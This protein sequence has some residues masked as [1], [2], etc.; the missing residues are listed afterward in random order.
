M[1]GCQMTKSLVAVVRCD[2]YDPETVY[3]AVVRAIDL[4]GGTE[5]FCHAGERIVL[6]P[7]ILAGA[8]PVAGLQ[9]GRGSFELWRFS[10]IS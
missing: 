6:K 9:G 4:I 1:A 3:C 10:R 5:A 7:N 8:D 2:S